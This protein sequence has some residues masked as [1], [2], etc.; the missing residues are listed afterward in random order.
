MHH[1]LE[2]VVS[3]SLVC[4]LFVAIAACT[5]APPHVESRG[6]LTEE[7]VVPPRDPSLQLSVENVDCA[8]RP[9]DFDPLASVRELDANSPLL[10]PKL[11]TEQAPEAFW[12]KFETTEGPIVAKFHREWAPIGVDRLYNLVQMGYYEGVAFFRVID[13][14]A[15]ARSS[16]AGYAMTY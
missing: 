8:A 9:L 4:L 10:N 12:V 6:P 5:S 2:N 3:R 1:R 16:A 13:G 15:K 11:A 7:G 14:F